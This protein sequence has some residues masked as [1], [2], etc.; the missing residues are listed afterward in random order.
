MNDEP[1]GSGS[2]RRVL[3]GVDGIPNS[4]TAPRPAAHQARYRDASLNIVYVIPAAAN[5]AAEVS[6]YEM[7][8]IA[9]RHVAPEGPGGPADRI[10]ARGERA[11]RGAAGG[12][13]LHE[14]GSEVR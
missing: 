2:R 3:V 8:G 12:A 4:L 7:P 6:S 14:T 9:L 10:V 1:A 11:P 13:R 5:K